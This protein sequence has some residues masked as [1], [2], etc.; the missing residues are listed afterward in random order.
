M[1][2]SFSLSQVV[3]VN[4]GHIT[5][6]STLS[7]MKEAKPWQIGVGVVVIG[8]AAVAVVAATGIDQSQADQESKAYRA[9]Q[10]KASPSRKSTERTGNQVAKA[11]ANAKVVRLYNGKRGADDLEAMFQIFKRFATSKSSTQYGT[12]DKSEFTNMLEE[13]KWGGGTKKL[14]GER[15]NTK[16]GK[17]PG[18]RVFSEA[19]GP[20]LLP[21]VSRAP[22]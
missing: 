4:S 15:A 6:G 11:L 8:V 3:Q 2:P 17:N 21:P 9:R 12:L 13:G 5:M 10:A 22:K 7:Q 14:S 16:E 18:G 20:C 19:G 1:K